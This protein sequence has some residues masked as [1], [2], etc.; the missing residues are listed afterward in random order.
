M[1]LYLVRHADALTKKEAQVASDEERPLS[2]EGRD[3]LKKARVQVSQFTPPLNSCL[4][5]PFLRAQQ[6]AKILLEEIP[7][8]SPPETFSGLVSEAPQG[9]L[10]TELEKRQN[11]EHIMLVG[12][13]PYMGLLLGFLLTGQKGCSVPFSKGGVACIELET[14]PPGGKS[15]RLRWFLN[16][17]I[18]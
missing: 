8:Q 6:T 12:H 16:P 7:C 18:V 2:E 1:R 3:F 17:P 10:L 15:S 13:E 9:D 4:V 11:E 14:I 5:S